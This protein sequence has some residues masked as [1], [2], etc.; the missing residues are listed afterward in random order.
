VLA[1]HNLAVL[2]EA[3]AE[4]NGDHA[5]L[6]FQLLYGNCMGHSTVMFRRS[7]FEEVGGYRPEWFPAEDYD[8]WL[9]M[10]SRTRFAVV[11][12]PLIFDSV[13]PDGISGRLAEAQGKSSNG[14]SRAAI[15]ELIGG[16]PVPGLLER[17]TSSAPLPCERL[18]EVSNLVFRAARGIRDACRV[19]GI[20]VA[21][22]RRSI[23][24]VLRPSRFRHASGR[25]CWRGLVRLIGR[26]PVVALA[27][28][29]QRVRRRA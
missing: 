23:T 10:A 3:A 2:A 14:L 13:D 5:S 28:A 7:V 17:T 16:E 24:P 21:S 9:R 27:S 20:P 12:A 26:H 29:R 25:R 19:R 6:W 1:E 18:D 22:L 4:S 11:R 15:A 8:L